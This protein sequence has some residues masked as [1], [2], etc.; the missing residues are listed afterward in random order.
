M[1]TQDV[2]VIG[3]GLAGLRCAAELAARGREVVVLEAADRVGGR[4]RTDR[5]DGFTLDRGF[6]VLNTAYPAVRSAVDVGALDVAAFPT[7]VRVRRTDGSMAT[8]A[9]PLRHPQLLPATLAGGLVTPRDVVGLARWLGPIVLRP[10]T[11]VARPDRTIGEGW[12]AA[13][14][15]GALRTQVLSPF[16]SGVLADS[17]ETTSDTY[18]RLLARSFLPAAAGLPRAGIAAL[19]VALASRARAA[20]ADIRLD[21]RVSRL[22]RRDGRWEVD[23]LGET[24]LLARDVVVAVGAEA[25]E[26]LVDVPGPS[27]RGLQTWWFSA[28]ETPAST[29]LTLD[30]SRGGPIVN[31]L[32]ISATIPEAAP[33]GRH[34]VQAT[35]LWSPGQVASESDV[36]AQLVRL[37]GQDS[38]SWRLL[39]RDDIPHALPALP[40][41]MR[42]SSPARIGP[43]LHLAGDHRESPSIQGALQSGLRAARSVLGEPLPARSSTR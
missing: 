40:P 13:G 30:G 17:S 43:G 25:V 14:L 5:V 21:R 34:L 3:A 11:A 2:V 12:D 29:L 20:G 19:P 32:A 38:A 35:C 18:V 37:Y 31:A 4:Q 8:L 39:R 24:T 26:G 7:A 22:R 15:T 41:P 36:R 33:H 16:F 6:H 42:R 27:T 1:Q 23:A 10:R 28:E 9:H